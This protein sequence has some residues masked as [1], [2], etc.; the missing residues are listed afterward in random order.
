MAENE[1]SKPP[2]LEAPAKLN[3]HVNAAKKVNFATAQNGVAILKSVEIENP[4]D[5]PVENLKLTLTASPAILRE[6]SWTI[7]R[8]AAGD[9]VKLPDL[10]ITLDSALLGGLNEAEIGQLQ[11]LLRAEGFQDEVLTLP[12]ELLAR[13]EWGGL[14][15]MDTVLA[16]FVSP[17]QPFVARILKEAAVILES[18]GQSG[19]MDGYQANDPGRVWMLVGA[20][21]SALTAHGLTYAVPPKS[22]E[23]IG[24]KV[25]M[26]ERVASEGLATCLDTSLL[27]AA[28]FEAAGLNTAVI[29]AEGHAWTGVWLVPRDFGQLVEPDI[30]ELRKAIVAREFVPLETTLLTRRPSVGLEEAVERG[31]DRLSETHETEFL[32]A[33][34]VN[35][36]RAARIRPLASHLIGDAVEPVEVAAV[37]A[38][39][40]K[41]L[42][43]GLLPSEQSEV[44]PDTALG[45]IERWQR[46]LLDL[47]LRNKLLNFKDARSTVPMICPDPAGVEDQLADG[48]EFRLLALRDEQATAGRDLSASEARQIEIGVAKEA[49]SRKQL[50]VPLTSKEMTSRLIGL[51]RKAKLDMAEGGTNTLFLAM[52]FLRWKRSESDQRS[53]RA[54]I[55]LLPVRLNRRSAKSEFRLSLFEDEVRVNFTLLEMLK[56]DFE[57]RL[58]ELE[59]ELPRDASGLDIPRIFE[60]LRQRVRDVAGFEVVEETAL[61]TFSFAKYLMWKDLV[62]RTDSLRENPMVAHLVDNPDQP[63][64]DATRPMPHPSDIDR[65]HG[66]GDFVAPM[67]ADSSQLSAVVAA[68]SG[69]NFVLIGPPGTGKSQTITN[70]IADQLARGRTVLFVAEKSAALN[71]VQRRLSQLGLGD[72]V[73]ELHSNKADRKTVLQQ[74][75]RSWARASR[76]G[77]QDWVKVS[78]DL[79]LTRDQLNAYVEALHR[80]GT[81]GF[82][83]YQAVGL[84]IQ[85]APPFSLRFPNKDCHDATAWAGLCTLAADLGALHARVA[86]LDPNGPIALLDNGE[87]SFGWQDRFLATSKSLK[88]AAADLAQARL[89]C[90]AL[91]GLPAEI[92]SE[93]SVAD[94][95]IVLANSRANAP[96][97][98][99]PAVE[100]LNNMKAA[101]QTLEANLAE[102][103]AARQELKA[104]YPNA[105]LADIPVETLDLQWREAQGKVWPFAGMA[106]GKVRKM[107]QTFAQ[108]GDADPA[109]DLPALKRLIRVRNEIAVSPLR[110]LTG[111]DGEDSDLAALHIQLERATDFLEVERQ[112]IAAGT[113]SS[114]LDAARLELVKPCGGSHG[115]S[116]TTLLNANAA[117]EAARREF[118]DLGGVE[119]LR[120]ASLLDGMESLS[121]R[122]PDW[123]KW[124]NG[125]AKAMA[126]GLAPL[127]EALEEGA[128]I[129]DT[130]Q[131]FEIAYMRWWLP[132]AMDAAEPLRAF[133]QWQHEDLIRKFRE[134]DS[135]QARLAAGEV[136]RRLGN[137]LPQ[138][139]S[140][141]RR[142]ELGE[143]R[144]QIG[145]QRPSKALRALISDLPTTFN[146]LA[147]CVLMSPLSVA[148]YLPAGQ[149][150]FDLVIFDEASQIS[151]WDAV[152]AI[153][154][155]KQ[156]IIV[157][158]PKQMPPSNFFGRADDG[159]DADDDVAIYEKDMPSILDEVNV[160]GIPIHRLSWHYRSRD[161]ALIAFSNHNYYDGGLV[162]FPA[163]TA[164]GQALRMHMVEGTY[165]RGKGRTNPDEAR[166]ITAFIC[167]RLRV[168]LPLEES[169]RPTLGVITFNQPQQALIQDLLDA[170]L[171]KDARLEWFFS[172]EREEPVIVKNLENI[173]GDERDVILFSITYGPD[174]SGKIPMSF[175]T[176][177]G[178]GGEK[179]LNVAVTRARAEMHIFSS[180]TADQID[181]SRTKARGVA[182]FKA[183]LDYAKRGAVALG[184]QDY[185]SLGGVDSPFEEAVLEALRAKGWD[186]RTQIGVSDYR[187]DLGVRHPDHAGAWLAG[188]ECDGARYHS[189][190]TARDRDRVRQAVLEGLG[191]K[192]LRI[193]STE[194]FRAPQ[195]TLEGVDRQLHDLLEKDRSRRE[196]EERSQASA[197]ED[198][199]EIAYPST[200]TDAELK[201]G[202]QTT[203]VSDLQDPELSD[204]I[205][206]ANCISRDETTPD[207]HGNQLH[208]AHEAAPSIGDIQFVSSTLSALDPERF[209][210]D[211]YEPVLLQRMAQIVSE[212][213]PMTTD[214]LA[215][216]IAQDHGWQRTGARIR[217]RVDTILPAFV[218]TDESGTSFV[219]PASGPSD[220]VPFRGMAGRSVRDI[221]VHEIASLLD[222]GG[223][224]IS[225]SEDP[226]LELARQMGIA[227]LSKDA[228]AYLEHC[229]RLHG[230]VP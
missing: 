219:W 144:H 221:S 20:I 74:L 148:Q 117:H 69:R 151:T 139:D 193:W 62:D 131:A 7:D 181:L 125:R 217:A 165:M 25:R 66:P 103:K 37:A 194:W 31:R 47:S 94:A 189:S 52:G 34:D 32:Q 29:F 161:E 213:A 44:A 87:W 75:D 6:K 9:T 11:F 95:L 155:G 170:E 197:G 191:W 149:A 13:D 200:N 4:L 190:A 114:Q 85:A 227:R 76:Q 230:E 102:A 154:R 110:T 223:A 152:G 203:P 119:T 24:Q 80:E 92:C 26:P 2:T 12:V 68:A 41:P 27:L 215:K 142:S 64:P 199:A 118:V 83:V 88:T 55:L 204:Q 84:A 98:S 224:A 30:I 201:D 128:E 105:D 188:V 132:L 82:S 180:I 113:P 10:E 36:A 100:D 206:D 97:V 187:I 171:Q 185:G 28:A 108:S 122:F 19:A 15:E 123:L 79:R 58:P 49:L 167:Q 169:K 112:L 1:T 145:L 138:R 115:D 218:I 153:A 184:G 143:L 40:P 57:L 183:F 162:T 56:R 104:V 129:P 198:A 222:Q 54:P 202:S 46:K 160:A 61:S 33:V 22:F 195:A 109:S 174:P 177:N 65:K 164:E 107:L 39:L 124:R 226:P 211:D 158:D 134:L 225:Q 38:A 86:D 212:Q 53:Y 43:L 163:P 21:W 106:Q 14:A 140:V 205:T 78:D 209:F 71:V 120:H 3:L 150:Q 8:V 91:I 89:K 141:P 137:D 156:A 90:G 214:N 48:T 70:I 16:A 178:Q 96:E 168:W 207:F 50:S 229:I 60:T 77:A 101:L 173:Q 228:R 5:H 159:D 157:G 175:G 126:Q 192:I 51:F 121:P 116:F 176:L 72:A 93:G 99:V 81:Q 127:V 59:G 220:R 133:A 136:L 63:F 135:Q 73:L 35:R 172:D 146:K 147:P 186:V 23:A 42:D 182:D 67:P 17:N 210:E 179:R 208:F 45:R 18:S 166:A 196:E 130:R 111:F 216:Q